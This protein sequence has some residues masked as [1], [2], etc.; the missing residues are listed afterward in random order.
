MSGNVYEW[1]WDRYGDYPRSGSVDPVG[2]SSGPNRMI[3]GGSWY[4]D[5]RRARVAGRDW[6]VPGRRGIDLGLRLVRTDP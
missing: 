1:C 3:R 5:P 2:P 4:Y 6:D